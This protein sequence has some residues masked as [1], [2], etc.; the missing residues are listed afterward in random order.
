MTTLLTPV[1]TD[2]WTLT[3]QSKLGLDLKADP[4]I[5]K[6]SDLSHVDLSQLFEQ[7]S[8]IVEH[9]ANHLAIIISRMTE[10][11]LKSLFADIIYE[12]LGNGNVQN[13]H[14]TLFKKFLNTF[15]P[16]YKPNGIKQE[17]TRELDKYQEMINKENLY[18]AI[19]LGGAG[20]ECICQV[21]LSAM[22]EQ[23]LKNP[24]V[25]KHHSDI[26]WKFWRIHTGP[27]DLEHQQAIK[28]ALKE[29]IF[30]NK[31]IEPELIRGYQSSLTFWDNFLSILTD[32]K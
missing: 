7:Y 2:F 12:E 13:S 8:F 18:F 14:F 27:V 26:H 11:S 23:M 4:R 15:N 1:K 29:E 28:E 3:D 32:F 20:T 5:K 21:Y 16:E 6:I 17:L 9:H 30:R 10:S 31:Y 22:Y 24:Y 25:I 19:G